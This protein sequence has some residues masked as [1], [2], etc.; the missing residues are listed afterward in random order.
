MKLLRRLYDW[1]LHWADTPYGIPALFLLSFAESSFFPIPPDVLLIALVI[2]R[3]DKAFRFALVC[4]AGSVLG[5]MFGY[6]LGATFGP[7]VWQTLAAWHVPAF[8]PEN[9]VKIQGIY[10]KYNFWA[11]FA[12]GFSPIP[13]KLFTVAGGVFAINFPVF[14]IASAV[15]RSARFFIVSALLWKFGAP[16][17]AFIDK[18]FNLLSLLFVALL[19]GGFVAVKYLL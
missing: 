17:K 3:P 6:W 5:G 19:I 8:T 4:S 9:F 10:E 2:G 7:P 13:Y 16:M 14:V 15:S 12:A 1:V 18:Y 11:V